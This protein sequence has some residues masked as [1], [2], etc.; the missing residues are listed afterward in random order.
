METTRNMVCFVLFMFS[1]GW[2]CIEGEEV[3]LW[4]ECFNIET[5]TSLNLSGSGLI[6]EIPPEIGNLVNLTYLFLYNNQL[7][8]EIPPEIGNLTNLTHLFLDNNQL[9]G[10]I[11]IEICDLVNLT[12]LFLDNNQLTGEIPESICDCFVF[13]SGNDSMGHNYFIFSNNY[14]CPPYPECLGEYSIGEQYCY[15]DYLGDI[16]YDGYVNIYDIITLVNCVI[17]DNCEVYYDINFD[18]EI[19]IIDIVTLVDIILE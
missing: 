11:P 9:T 15:D 19:T 4:G 10:E 17:S 5:T 18:N 16:N 8:G 12:F 14:L 13:R 3:E 2:G 1:I 6:G 7:T